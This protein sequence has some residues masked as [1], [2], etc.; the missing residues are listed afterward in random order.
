MKDRARNYFS[1]AE[2]YLE[3]SKFLL[4]NLMIIQML[5]LVQHKIS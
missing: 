2:Q 4:E 5:V 3:T 1:L